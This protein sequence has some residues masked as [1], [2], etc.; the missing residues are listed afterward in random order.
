MG[1][2]FP[3]IMKG[4]WNWLSCYLQGKKEQVLQGSQSTYSWGQE[5]MDVEM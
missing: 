4:F 5:S 1:V 2:G 3:L